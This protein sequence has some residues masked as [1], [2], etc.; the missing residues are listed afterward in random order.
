MTG[1]DVVIVGAGAA[2]LAAARALSERGVAFR[3]LEARDRIGGRILTLESG[4]GAPIELGPELVHGAA[5]PAMALARDARV[6]L[7][8]TG[9]VAAAIA[10][11]REAAG[12]AC[13][14]LGTPRRAASG[15]RDRRISPCTGGLRG[16]S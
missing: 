8:G 7:A 1:T 11:S 10:S 15:S 3:V 6:P 5:E 13:E 14:S 16:A 9:T 2:G 12:R 4:A